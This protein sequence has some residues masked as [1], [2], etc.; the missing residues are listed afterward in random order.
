MGIYN[1]EASGPLQSLCS[2]LCFPSVLML[3]GHLYLVL[4]V[5]IYDTA[6]LLTAKPVTGLCKGADCQVLCRLLF[7]GTVLKTPICFEMGH[8]MSWYN[9]VLCDSTCQ[10]GSG[11]SGKGGLFIAR[12]ISQPKHADCECLMDL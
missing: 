3:P 2:S 6:T 9:C 1:W 11:W 7:L 4:V 12:A 10:C 5:L 8:I